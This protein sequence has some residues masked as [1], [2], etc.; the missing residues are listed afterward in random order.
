MIY[1]TFREQFPNNIIAGMF[2]FKPT[3]QLQLE[4]PEARKAPEV[5]F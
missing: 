5:S 3:E 4:S 2:A 1:N